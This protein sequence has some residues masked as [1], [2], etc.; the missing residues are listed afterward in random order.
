MATDVA[1]VPPSSS[2]PV[3][4]DVQYPQELSRWL[5]FVKWLLSIPHYIILYFLQLAMMVVVFIGFFAIL[6]TK[7]YPQSLFNFV[8]GVTRWNANYYAYNLL[9]RDEYPPFSMDA[10]QYPVAYDV[11]YPQQL[12][13]WLIFVKWLLIIP[14]AIVMVIVMFVAYLVT[15]VAWF[16]I[17]FTKKYPDSLFKFVVGALRWS[18]RTNAYVLLLTDE[19]P[20]FSMEP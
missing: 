19:Y 20:P 2:Y 11:A 14:N 3:T 15:I 8:V 12:S 5:I 18:Q 1:A 4:F 9:L 16:S 6:L 13:R 17:L 10:G 7:R